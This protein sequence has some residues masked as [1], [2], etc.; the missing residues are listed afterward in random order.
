M[1]EDERMTQLAEAVATIVS[2]LTVVL[3]GLVH[4]GRTDEFVQLITDIRDAVRKVDTGGE[5]S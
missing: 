3:L 2:S 4:A 5:E 1:A